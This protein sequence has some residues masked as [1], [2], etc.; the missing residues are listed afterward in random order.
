MLILALVD[1]L[2]D[3]FCGPTVALEKSR[4]IGTLWTSFGTESRA[5]TPALGC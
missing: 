2:A 1:V 3:A 5:F 4:H